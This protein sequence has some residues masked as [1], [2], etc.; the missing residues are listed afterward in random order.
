MAMGDWF[1]YGREINE[2]EA[3]GLR[4]GKLGRSVLRP[5][6]SGASELWEQR[7]VDVSGSRRRLRGLGGRGRLL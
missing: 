7:K 2:E 1:G 5:Y 6:M 4:P 3:M